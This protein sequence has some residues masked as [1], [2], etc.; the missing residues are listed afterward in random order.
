LCFCFG[1]SSICSL[2]EGYYAVNVSSHFFE[3]VFYFVRESSKN[4]LEKKFVDTESWTGASEIRS[5][6][7]Q[8]AQLDRAVAVSQLDDKPVYFYAPTKF[9]GDQRL[10]YNQLI[11]FTLR[12]QGNVAPSK[13]YVLT[14]LLLKLPFISSPFKRHHN[15]RSEWPGAFSS[16]FRPIQSC[17]GTC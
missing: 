3:G 6:D 9:L 7:V 10:A 1:H 5:E 17:A 13:Q 14:L 8:W 4:T 2:A 11:G 12:V 15:C 16:D